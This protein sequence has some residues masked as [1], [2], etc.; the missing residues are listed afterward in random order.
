MRTSDTVDTEL[1][2]VD[3]SD[4]QEILYEPLNLKWQQILTVLDRF[5]YFK[6]WTQAQRQDCCTLSTIQQYAPLDT[7]YAEDVGKLNS[8]FFVL[9]GEC[10][11][12]QC[13]KMKVS[14]QVELQMGEMDGHELMWV[15]IFSSISLI[16]YI[17][18]PR[19]VESGTKWVSN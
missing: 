15:N 18:R 3:V 10:R 9:S 1:L 11:I 19:K 14:V 5:A 2:C 7:I 12:L 8:V 4:F 6:N 16:R 13:L 17:F